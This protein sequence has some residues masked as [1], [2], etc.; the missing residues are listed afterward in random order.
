MVNL[1][2][3]PSGIS[4]TIQVFG[5]MYLQ[6]NGATAFVKESG[7]SL[8]GW[9]STDKGWGPNAGVELLTYGLFYEWTLPISSCVLGNDHFRLRR[10]TALK[11]N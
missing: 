9:I 6:H 5:P 2:S 10:G 3:G 11:P 8:R 1:R 7:G 4:Q